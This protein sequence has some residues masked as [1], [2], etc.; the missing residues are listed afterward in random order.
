MRE[1]A[2]SQKISDLEISAVIVLE[3]QRYVELSGWKR[4]QIL[5]YASLFSGSILPLR[6][7]QSLTKLT[8]L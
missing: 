5:L 2:K 4:M 7:V 8:T 1:E 3:F 6:E